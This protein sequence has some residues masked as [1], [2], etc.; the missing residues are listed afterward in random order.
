MVDFDKRKASNGHM[1]TPS[2]SPFPPEA[3][4]SRGSES[5]PLSKGKEMWAPGLMLMGELTAWIVGPIIL[6]LFVGK[7][8]DQ[9]YSSEPWF[10]LGLVGI[11]FIITA[12]KIVQIGKDYIKKIEQEV[13]QK[14]S[15]KINS[16][17][18]DRR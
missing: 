2:S 12:W 13:Q 6:A 14:Q 1:L 15:N 18:D 9:K 7:W 5:S 3:D 10:F 16:N 17:G 8:L 4:K 11:A